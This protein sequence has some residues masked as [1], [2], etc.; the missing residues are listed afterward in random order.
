MAGPKA[1]DTRL[2]GCRRSWM[3][4]PLSICTL[5]SETSGVG[6]GDPLVSALVLCLFLFVCPEGQ[7]MKVICSLPYFY[8]GISLVQGSQTPVLESYSVFS[9][10]DKFLGLENQVRGI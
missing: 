2:R 4:S 10:D 1:S 3:V 8:P 7:E 6:L 9:P 5:R